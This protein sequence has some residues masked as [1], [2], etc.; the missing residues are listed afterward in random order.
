MHINFDSV[1]LLNLLNDLN[2]LFVDDNF[3]SSLYPVV[4][5]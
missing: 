5:V 1:T 4:P 3:V 2:T